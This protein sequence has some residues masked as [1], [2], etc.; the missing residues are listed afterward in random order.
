MLGKLAFI[1]YLKAVNVTIELRSC[2]TKRTMEEDPKQIQYHKLLKEIESDPVSNE[3]LSN[4][5][6]GIQK[7]NVVE[8][9]NEYVRQSGLSKK[10]QDELTI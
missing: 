10:E 5:V 2:A 1:R 9:Y 7:E 3:I 6:E 4:L 8:R